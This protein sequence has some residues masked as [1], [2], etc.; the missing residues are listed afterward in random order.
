VQQSPEQYRLE[1]AN[2]FRFR[3]KDTSTDGKLD[4]VANMLGQLAPN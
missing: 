4:G 3:L 2:S 1:G